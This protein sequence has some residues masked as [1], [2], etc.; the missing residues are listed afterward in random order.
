LQLLCAVVCYDPITVEEAA[1]AIEVAIACVTSAERLLS[2]D[3]LG[4]F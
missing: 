1:G 4:V 3:E 2:V